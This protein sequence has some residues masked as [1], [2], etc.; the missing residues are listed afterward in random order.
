MAAM[1]VL[2]RQCAGLGAVFG[3]FYGGIPA[4]VVGLVTAIVIGLRRRNGE[5]V[6]GIILTRTCWGIVVV[7]ALVVTC[8]IV[9][10]PPATG[11]DCAL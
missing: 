11:T 3:V 8:A 1:A 10:A 2:S 7:S 6:N 9:F 5:V 4:I